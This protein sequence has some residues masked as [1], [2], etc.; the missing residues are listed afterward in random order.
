V[1]EETPLA[2]P[3]YGMGSSMIN[4]YKKTFADDSDYPQVSSACADRVT[5]QKLTP[6]AFDCSVQNGSTRDPST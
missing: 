2:L 1:Q 4:Y 5:P 3:G 6:L